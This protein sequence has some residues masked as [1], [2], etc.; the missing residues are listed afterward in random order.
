MI[1]LGGKYHQ[2]NAKNGIFDFYG[3]RNFLGEHGP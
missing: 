2:E 1:M 3:F